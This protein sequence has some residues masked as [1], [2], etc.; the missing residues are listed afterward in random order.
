MG[1]CRMCGNKLNEDD[2]FCTACGAKVK[3]VNTETSSQNVESENLNDTNQ[4]GI[5]YNKP[6]ISINNGEGSNTLKTGINV[7]VHNVLKSPLMLVLAIL[8]SL[9]A[10]LVL[11]SF[12]AGN[13]IAILSSLLNLLINV[14]LTIG[15]WLTYA[16]AVK[17]QDKISGLVNAAV[18]IKFIAAI[19]VFSLLGLLLIFLLVGLDS[20]EVEIPAKYIIIFF[21]VLGIVCAV[22]IV[23]YK[24]ILSYLKSLQSIYMGKSNK[25]EPDSQ[26]I[27]FIMLFIVGG[28]ELLFL[29]A[30]TALISI[31]EEQLAGLVGLDELGISLSNSTSDFTTFIYAATMIFAGVLIII[32]GNKLKSANNN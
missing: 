30:K 21:F 14:F 25:N 16:G 27:T 9:N 28:F 18:K 11:I 15:C 12:S 6:T 22:V 1:F 13:F 31:L 3:S 26:T 17:G 10:L 24:A 19:V 29:V 5:S 7:S 23:F 2:L 4:S 32:L 20:L 8:V